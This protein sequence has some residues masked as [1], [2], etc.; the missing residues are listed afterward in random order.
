MV[1]ISDKTAITAAV[2]QITGL[3]S[4]SAGGFLSLLFVLW[5]FSAACARWPPLPSQSKG[6]LLVT[7]NDTKMLNV[8]MRNFQIKTLHTNKCATV[9]WESKFMIKAWQD[10]LNGGGKMTHSPVMRILSSSFFPRK[11][12]SW[13]TLS[14]KVG[15]QRQSFT[16]YNS[17]NWAYFRILVGLLEALLASYLSRQTDTGSTSWYLPEDDNFCSCGR[18]TTILHNHHD[19]LMHLFAVLKF[20]KKKKSTLIWKIKVSLSK[21]EI[22]ISSSKK[23]IFLFFSNYS[24]KK[25]NTFGVY[26]P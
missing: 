18:R 25:N 3:L 26:R 14:Y 12:G 24:H 2:T 9:T 6:S 7:Q 23:Y 4:H 17:W 15:I 10:A 22:Y 13:Y 11:E 8:W 20:R 21:H 19:W 5:L 16:S 1:I